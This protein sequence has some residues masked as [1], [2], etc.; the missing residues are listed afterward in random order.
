MAV[1]VNVFRGGVDHEHERDHGHGNFSQI[2]SSCQG[3]LRLL[4]HWTMRRVP[5]YK[6]DASYGKSGARI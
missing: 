5:V 3:E 1:F 4:K 6:R 2:G